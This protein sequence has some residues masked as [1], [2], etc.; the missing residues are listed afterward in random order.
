MALV[1]IFLSSCIGPNSQSIYCSELGRIAGLCTTETIV[2][3]SLP[4]E[5]DIIL[6][7]DIFEANLYG[8]LRRNRVWQKWPEKS[9]AYCEGDDPPKFLHG[10]HSSAHKSWSGSGRF[11]A[12]AYPVHQLCYPN[13][14]P[15]PSDVAAVPKDLLFSFV[16]RVSHQVRKRL[17]SLIFPSD[18]VV[19]KNTT[20]YNHFRGEEDNLKKARIRYW[21]LAKR[22]KYVLC[23]RGAGASSIRIFEM[24]EAG[25]AP[26]IIAD[27]WL[28][29]CGPKW[30]E[31]ALFVP[32][33]EIG[34]VYERV[35]V[36]EIEYVQRGRLARKAW[37]QFFSPENYWHFILESLRQIQKQQK[38]SESTYLKL[39]PFMVAQEWFRQQQIQVTIRLKSGIKSVISKMSRRRPT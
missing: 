11:Q 32:E 2:L 36:H 27:D 24:L 35:K 39:V 10:L 13:P 29:P 37:E 15:P 1:K 34:L 17:F 26:V 22:S 25:I 5:A 18:E 3:V 30:E 33:S 7:A 21:D 23:P 19:I 14:C 28:P 20:G 38:I 6:I 4:E 9:F 16:G 12:C 31:F 8:G